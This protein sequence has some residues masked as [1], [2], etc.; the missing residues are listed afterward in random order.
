VSI[1]AIFSLE[2]AGNSNKLEDKNS[3]SEEIRRIL[4][5]LQNIP[6]IS[7]VWTQNHMKSKDYHVIINK[8]LHEKKM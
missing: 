3:N 2:G 5:K 6:R 4:G 7:P 8:T 1:G